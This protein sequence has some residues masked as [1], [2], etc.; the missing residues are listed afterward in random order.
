MEWRQAMERY[1]AEMIATGDFPNL[2]AFAGT[3]WEFAADVRFEQ[4]LEW[5]LD[6]IAARYE[7]PV[8][9]LSR[10]DDH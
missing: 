4:G 3:D 7:R 9:R 8:S 6:G 2:E 1:W 5:M 10:H